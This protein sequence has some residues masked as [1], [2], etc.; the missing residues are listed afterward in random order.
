MG[1]LGGIVNTT[2]GWNTMWGAMER[3][4]MILRIWDNKGRRTLNINH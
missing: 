2:E 1:K 4:G 3:E